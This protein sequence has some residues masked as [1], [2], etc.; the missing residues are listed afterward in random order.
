MSLRFD[1]KFPG[2]NVAAVRILQDESQARVSFS[3]HPHGGSQALWFHFRLIESVPSATHPE[4]VTITLEF[5]QTL[6]GC[7]TPSEL[8]PVFRMEGQGWNR[9]R[10][11]RVSRENGQVSVSW[12][13]PYPSPKTEI[14]FCYPYGQPE[15]RTLIQKSKGYWSAA[16]IGLSHNGRY[17]QRL[18][19]NIAHAQSQSGLY[20]I[21]QQ[22]AGETPGCWVLDGILQH[23]SRQNEGRLFIWAVPQADAGGIDRGH[24]GRGGTATDLDQ[25]WG[26][27][28][29]RY[30]TRAIQAD[31]NEWQKQCKPA[32]VLDLQSAG[33]TESDGVYCYLSSTEASSDADKWANMI[34]VALGEQ[35]AASNFK[36]EKPAHPNGSGLSVVDYVQ[37][38]LS[39]SALSLV[40]PYAS[41]GKISMAPKQYREVGSRIARALLQRAAQH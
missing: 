14:A 1:A 24:Y 32:L 17:I 16:P 33:G 41:C 19:N 7:D 8:N 18:R 31:L 30:E 23:F 20:L 29:L 38:T 26:I 40:I 5:V 13:I 34:R 28:P 21:A 15:I 2:G 35:F 36:R 6:T 11:G 10:G 12:N 39:T 9:T 22:H 25:A 4:T 27:S 3:P 37:K